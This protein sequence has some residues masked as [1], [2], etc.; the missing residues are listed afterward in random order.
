M[1][2][3]DLHCDTAFEIW[4]KGESLRHNTCHIA[5]DRAET[6]E[7]YTQVLAIWSEDG[8]SDED[9]WKQFCLVD[10]YLKKD[11]AAAP[12]FTPLLAVEG[13]QLLAGKLERMD[14]LYRRGVRILTLVWGGMS[15]IGGAFDDGAGLTGFGRDVVKRCFSLGIVPDLSHASDALFRDVTVLAEDAGKPVIASH[16]C[17]RQLCPHMRNLTDGMFRRIAELGG[18][19]GVNLVRSH[20]GGEVCDIDRVAEHLMHFYHI[21]GEDVVCLG[22]DMDGTDPLPDGLGGV[23][24]LP[25]LYD[26]VCEV[27]HSQ[28]IAD[29]IFY[30]NAQ[31]FFERWIR[32]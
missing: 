7:A 11:N 4:K 15:C 30:S 14:E 26:K 23:Q 27:A 32:V 18:V 31:N 12:F 8:L 29:K 6:F 9:A 21:G 22:C 5:L 16:S 17:S 1:K 10:D 19:V 20:L 13:A 3:F 25:K 24:D 2:L 28:R